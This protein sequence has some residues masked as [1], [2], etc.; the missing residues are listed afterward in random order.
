MLYVHVVALVDVVALV[1]V[2]WCLSLMEPR[3][4]TSGTQQ[5]RRSTQPLAST[6]SL[7]WTH[8]RK[9]CQGEAG[10]VCNLCESSLRTPSGTTTTLVNHLKRHANQYAEFQAAAK[11]KPANQPSIADVLRKTAL[12]QA[13]REA[14]DLKIAKMVALDLQPYTIVQDRGFWDLLKDAVPGY[15]PP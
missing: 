10:G 6:R 14:L 4:E 2:C 9:V 1:C 3:Q 15:L 5:P 11:V 7:A 12:P 13:K 8:F